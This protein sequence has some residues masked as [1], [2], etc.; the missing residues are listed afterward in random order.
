[1]SLFNRK[2]APQGMQKR[3]GTWIQAILLSLALAGAAGV[4]ARA[5]V[6]SELVAFKVVASGSKESFQAAT[7]VKPGELLEYRLDYRNK[8]DEA[9][10]GLEVTLP[11]PDT[12][13]YV[14]NT[15]Q[16][17][18][19]RASVDG[20]NFQPVPL[21]R[22]VRQADGKEIEQLVPV[23]EY[24]YLRWNPADLPAGQAAKYSARARV[25]TGAP[26]SPAAP[27]R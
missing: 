20:Q 3:G 10:R 18:A 27:A 26:V 1:M 13:E 23:S 15:A 16:P 14:A 4:Q 7:S 24:R 25:L 19:V 5:D 11:I 22:R 17:A 6:V 8:G 12:L 21:K 2:G 9:A